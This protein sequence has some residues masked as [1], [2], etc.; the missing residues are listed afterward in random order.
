MYRI[1][2][3]LIAVFIFACEESESTNN[4]MSGGST[5]GATAGGTVAG[6]SN[7]D[8]PKTIN[9]TY[10]A[11]NAQ[12]GEVILNAEVCIDGRECAT[13]DDE[14]KVIVEFTEG[15]TFSGSVKASNFMTARG[16]A[17]LNTSEDFTFTIP[18]IQEAIV[19]VLADKAGVE[20]VD[21][22]KG[23][24]VFL[25][26][27]EGMDTGARS[28]VS[29]SL[30]PS[31]DEIGPKYIKEGDVTELIADNPYDDNLESTSSSGLVNFYNVEP[32]EYTLTLTGADDCS[33]FLGSGQEDGSVGFDVKAGELSYVTVRC[34]I[35]E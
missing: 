14:G 30:E 19:T 28:N 29:V 20:S 6:G 18:L 4:E 17:T 35:Q 22:A 26:T 16:S 12:T 24:I 21:P 33:T 27:N 3:C 25:A 1:I 5:G 8:E 23:H 2:L 34:P 9:V 13:A 11:Q 31:G 15:D 10:M 32:G 7:A